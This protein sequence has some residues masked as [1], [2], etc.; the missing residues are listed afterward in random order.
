MTG[1]L[2]LSSPADQGG[3]L[4]FAKE[5]LLNLNTLLESLTVVNK[6]SACYVQIF[7]SP[8]K[9]AV[10]VTDTVALS[11]LITAPAHGFQT[12][13][14][15][16]FTGIAGLTS[17]Y[18]Q[19][20]SVDTIYVCSTRALALAGALPDLLPSGDGDTG[21]LDLYS[22]LASPPVP[23]EYPLAAE[24]SAPSNVLSYTNARFR[25]GV[26]ARGVTAINGSTLIAAADL[27]FTP[28]YRTG[29]LAGPV[30]YE[31]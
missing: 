19:N 12:G 21:F 13:D 31:D 28:R 27:K 1:L 22:N 26:Y 5:M 10:P 29:D 11:G 24:A 8:R 4:D 23:E 17:G 9:L 18:I 3:P 15:V 7:D 20:A 14:R 30:S 16:T 2:V 25:R 6:G